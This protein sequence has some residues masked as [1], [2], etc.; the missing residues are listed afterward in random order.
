MKF[1]IVAALCA[2]ATAFAPAT[3]TSSRG[4]ALKSTAAEEAIAAAKAASEK[5]GADS[6]EAAVAW[7]QVEEIDA[8]LS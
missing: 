8:A 2:S 5:F 4:F 6:P 7:E 3:F 1:Q